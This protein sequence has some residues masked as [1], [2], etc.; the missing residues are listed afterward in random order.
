M[1]INDGYK[2]LDISRDVRSWCHRDEPPKVPRNV[3]TCGLVNF[4]KRSLE[5][6][7]M[8]LSL[9]ILEIKQ[10]ALLTTPDCTVGSPSSPRPSTRARRRRVAQ[11]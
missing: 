2:M 8:G 5:T 1:R 7:E 3:P 9:D 4:V 6:A 11:R 10:G